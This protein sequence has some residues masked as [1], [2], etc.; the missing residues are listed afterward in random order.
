ML[1]AAPHSACRVCG[2]PLDAPAGSVCADCVALSQVGRAAAASPSPSASVT[3][4]SEPT[5]VPLEPASDPARET[6]GDAAKH[7][8]EE[9]AVVTVRGRPPDA[10]PA[11]DADARPTR[12]SLEAFPGAEPRVGDVVGHF[13]LI[14]ELGRGGMG[15]VWRAEDTGLRRQVALK[16]LPAWAL[17][18]GPVA[19]E[20][21]L[22]EAR[23]AARLEHPNIVAVHEIGCDRGRHH[24]ALQLLNGGS[25][26]DLVRQCG[27]LPPALA[28]RIIA[29]AAR[30]LAAAHSAG[31]IHRDIKPANILLAVDADRCEAE[32][33][34]GPDT[35]SAGHFPL[36]SAKLADFGL[37]KFAGGES[38][39]TIGGVVVG[40]PTYM[41]PEQAQGLTVD[42]R[43]DQYS[44]GAAYARLLLGRPV[45]V[46][47][48]S[49][50]VM[51]MH[52]REPLP[53]PAQ[54]G[55]A[56]PD[57]AWAVVRRAMEK[58]PAHRFATTADM[59][60]ALESLA[61][62]LGG[63]GG[64]P[65]PRARPAAVAARPVEARPALSIEPLPVAVAEPAPTGRGTVVLSAAV[66]LAALAAAA[67]FLRGGWTPEIEPRP[68]RGSSS[69]SATEPDP[70]R[71]G[72]PP[73]PK[74][75]GPALHGP[76][77][78]P[79]TAPPSAGAEPVTFP[80]DFLEARAAQRAWAARLGTE[81]E[82]TNSIGMRLVLL[83]PGRFRAG[84]PPDEPG[85]GA[86]EDLT[87]AVIPAP[88]RTGAFEVTRGQFHAVMGGR[89]PADADEAAMP[90][91]GMGY[92]L[93][94]SF[95]RK[96]SEL[97]AEKAA[98]RV[99]R[100]PTG[101]E[102]EYAC[103]A[104]SQ[105][106]FAWSIELSGW[107]RTNSADRAKPWPAGRKQPN[108]WGVYDTHGNAAEWVSDAAGDGSPRR[109]V[110]GGS[111]LSPT[112]ECRAAAR[113]LIDPASPSELR[114]V[115]LRVV[116]EGGLPR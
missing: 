114:S 43:S 39:L 92:A 34:S 60:A 33:G 40:T 45:F 32:D 89:G 47:D 55:V 44:L 22:L 59:A 105:R 99:Y 75:N 49:M 23:A 68:V 42:A 52:C 80:L 57:G 35:P 25:A 9:P 81:P 17:A 77:P 69:A 79:A 103:R 97:P 15:V 106:P 90:T 11:A 28:T 50:Q 93:A 7:A 95:C 58:D 3:A 46:G 87:D 110:R 73:V 108:A 64:D 2:N 20:R 13:R 61:A 30:G 14:G 24:I 98:G 65:L 107:D 5:L 96:L 16:I 4:V 116:C 10:D 48:S 102:W 31:V 70:G 53:D 27:P 67:V 63:A 86:G 83:P 112:P 76:N 51:Y 41:S 94:E 84:S 115:G 66:G 37:A 100:L 111:W 18:E 19:L 26:E 88:L 29:D 91:V 6:V 21:F 78:K 74:P 113:R 85:R 72:A 56:V 101:A 8:A 104:G 1:S 62:D 71:S 12:R 54:L 109:F 38:N 82:I 36:V